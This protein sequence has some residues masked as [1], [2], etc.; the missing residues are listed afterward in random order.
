MHAISG[1][2][3]KL[4]IST[5]LLRFTVTHPVQRWLIYV[6]TCFYT[7]ITISQL[8][9]LGFQCKPLAYAWDKSIKGGSCKSI[10]YLGIAAYFNATTNAATDFVLASIPVWLI[11]NLKLDIRTKLSVGLVLSMGNL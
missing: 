10:S 11:W 2:F 7:L 8:F 1:L 6:T 3:L 5:L 9:V 4:S